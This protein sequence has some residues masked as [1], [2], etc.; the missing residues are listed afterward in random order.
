MKKTVW[1]IDDDEE[2]VRAVQMMLKLLDCETRYFYS[3]RHAVDTLQAGANVDLLVVDIN[4]PEISGIDLLEYLRRQEKWR[5]LPIV[6]LSTE[7][8]DVMVDRALELGADAYVT[9][10]V[11]IEELQ[12]AMDRAFK[13][14]EK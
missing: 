2:M 3:A 7:A 5:S 1:L 12:A 10:P 8:A 6:M 9:K 11:A 4:M 14:H 13:A